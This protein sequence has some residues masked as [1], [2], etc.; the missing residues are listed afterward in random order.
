LVSKLQRTYSSQPFEIIPRRGVLL[1]E[2]NLGQSRAPASETKRDDGR[3]TLLS[4]PSFLDCLSKSRNRIGYRSLPT[5]A[6]I[7][8]HHYTAQSVE[9]SKQ[10]PPG[11]RESSR[12]FREK[13]QGKDRD[14]L[15]GALRCRDPPQVIAADQNC[16][17]K[18]L[19]CRRCAL[20]GEFF[21]GLVHRCCESV[22]NTNVG[23]DARYIQ[24]L[25]F[26]RTPW[27]GGEGLGA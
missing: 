8:S 24:D 27:I 21:P 7:L 13:I 10:E 5:Q 15:H 12:N 4:R 2:P 23:R 3:D 19:L 6:C 20:R 16:T 11:I 14:P 26:W 9:K 1:G 17:E 22:H 18:C 25:V